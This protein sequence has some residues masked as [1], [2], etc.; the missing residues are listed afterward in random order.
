M[1]SNPQ[2]SLFYSS[3]VVEYYTNSK[4]DPANKYN[5]CLAFEVR[6]PIP[7]PRSAIPDLCLKTPRLYGGDI[8]NFTDDPNVISAV[9]KIAR[10][11]PVPFTH[12]YPIQIVIFC[13]MLYVRKLFTKCTWVFDLLVMSPK[14]WYFGLFITKEHQPRCTFRYEEYCHTHTKHSSAILPL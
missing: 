14:S 3:T 12:P 7:I 11:E 4:D 9:S 6:G 10:R 8:E 2:I 1:N 5:R 13:P